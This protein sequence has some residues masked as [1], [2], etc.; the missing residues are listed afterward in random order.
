MYL[1]K[2]ELQK[3]VEKYWSML[4]PGGVMICI[5]PATEFLM[6]WRKLTGKSFAS[7][8]GGNVFHFQKNTLKDLFVDLKNARIQDEMSV[9]LLPGITSSSLHHGFAVARN[10]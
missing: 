8:T 1:N 5:E 9:K 10:I 4:S 3:M 7:P 2:N 6:L